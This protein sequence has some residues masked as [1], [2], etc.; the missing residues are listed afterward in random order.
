MER[1]PQ[2]EKEVEVFEEHISQPAWWEQNSIV[3]EA[4]ERGEHWNCCMA[5]W[6]ECDDAGDGDDLYGIP[7]EDMDLP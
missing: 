7:Y 5:H 2:T 3:C 1:I 6:C 4:C